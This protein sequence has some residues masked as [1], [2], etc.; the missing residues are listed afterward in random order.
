MNITSYIFGCILALLFGALFHLWRGG[1]LGKLLLFLTLSLVGFFLGHLVFEHYK[2]AFMNVGGVQMA[3]GIVG[4]LIFLF[5]GNWFSH[6]RP[7][8][9]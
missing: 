5:L 8:G 4:S 2:V 1:G 6:V 3:G 9:E 7:Q